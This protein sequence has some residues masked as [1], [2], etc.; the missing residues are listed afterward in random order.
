M[1]QPRGWPRSAL[2]LNA[3]NQMFKKMSWVTSSAR[4]GCL[5]MNIAREYTGVWYLVYKASR[6][7]LSTWV[8]RCIN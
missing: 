8:I 2:K 7:S 6:A 4:A 5:S 3:F 1:I